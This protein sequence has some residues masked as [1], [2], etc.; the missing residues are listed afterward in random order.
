MASQYRRGRSR[1]SVH[2]RTVP[3]E[4]IASDLESVMDDPSCRGD[5]EDDLEDLD[6]GLPTPGDSEPD[7]DMSM[8]AL[9]MRPAGITFSATT[10]P[11]MA[12]QDPERTGRTRFATNRER[13]VSRNAERSLLRDNHLLPP[14]HWRSGQVSLFRRVYRYFFSTKVRGQPPTQS[15]PRQV[16]V[17]PALRSNTAA[18]TGRVHRRQ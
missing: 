14:K 11:A 5:E 8:S 15:P 18:T 12:P 16:A 4:I 10:R 17:D 3:Q 6:I 9:F 7:P 1:S 13:E 2:Y